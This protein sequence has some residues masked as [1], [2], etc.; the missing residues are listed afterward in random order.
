MSWLMHDLDQLSFFLS[1]TRGSLFS[2]GGMG[3]VPILHADFLS[4][5]WAN[6]SDFAQA[7][8][9]GQ[10]SPGPTGLWVVSFGYLT[11]GLVG[12]LLTAMAIT[13]PPFL[14]LIVKTLHGRLERHP[15]VQGFVRGLGL[16]ALG[17]FGY[18][19]TRLMA[20]AGFSVL[21]LASLIFGAW[22]AT[23]KRVPSIAIIGAAAIAGIVF[24]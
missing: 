17:S 10:L 11:D 3:N 15:A 12:A 23:N 18:V 22:L 2:T 5:G 13:L 20:Q 7:I 1:I 9:I 6:D 19:L 24:K 8:S 21:T 16:A 14:I 4:R